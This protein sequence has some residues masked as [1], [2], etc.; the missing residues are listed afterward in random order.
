M[1]WIAI[2]HL[3]TE[4]SAL[5]RRFEKFLVASADFRSTRNF[6]VL[7]LG[8]AVLAAVPGEVTTVAGVRMKQAL[9]KSWPRRRISASS[10]SR[11]AICNTSRQ[12]RSIEAQDY[13]GGST[14]YGPNT[15]AALTEE[16]ATLAG[17]LK[18][19]SAGAR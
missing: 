13:E 7:Q 17:T 5:T 9:R 15:A 14:I 19:D 6:A 3:S 12:R 4:R 16:L 8:N 11:T 1:R 10:V 18:R 2:T